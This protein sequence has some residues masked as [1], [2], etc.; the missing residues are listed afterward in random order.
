MQIPAVWLDYHA[1]FNSAI[2]GERSCDGWRAGELDFA[3]LT[4]GVGL[5]LPLLHLAVAAVTG[6]VG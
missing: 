5:V 2:A 6:I 4:V 1:R 3:G